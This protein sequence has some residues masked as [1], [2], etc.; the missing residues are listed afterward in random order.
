MKHGIIIF[1]HI[2]SFQDLLPFTLLPNLPLLLPLLFLPLSQ[3]PPPC[4]LPSIFSSL[5]C[6][7]SF[8]HK[9]LHSWYLPGTLRAQVESY[10]SS[11]GLPSGCYFVRR[12]NKEGVKASNIYTLSYLD[13]TEKVTE[14]TKTVGR[15][16]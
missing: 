13:K 1:H 6:S 16:S 15:W 14:N 4:P 7:P 10:L 12:S 3:S 2:V 5:P 8:F 9:T 11:P